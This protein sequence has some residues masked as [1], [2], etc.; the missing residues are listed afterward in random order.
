MDRIKGLKLTK[1]EAFSA[2]F[3][4]S[5]IIYFTYPEIE[6][7]M[8]QAKINQMLKTSQ[9]LQFYVE[10]H[11]DKGKF[12]AG[13]TQ[14]QYFHLSDYVRDFLIEEDGQITLFGNEHAGNISITL[15][16]KQLENDVDIKWECF[17]NTKAHKK[18]KYE[19]YCERKS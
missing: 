1:L 8:L 15:N 12:T 6:H 19:P 2:L 3:V 4:V 17:V 9:K 11:M 14:G 18:I 16:P 13:I 5:L 7:V 10:K